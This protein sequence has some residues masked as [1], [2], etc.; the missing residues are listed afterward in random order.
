MNLKSDEGVDRGLSLETSFTRQT[1]LII[2][3]EGVSTLNTRTYFG[4]RRNFRNAGNSKVVAGEKLEHQ[5]S[6][7]MWYQILRDS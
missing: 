2:S 7:C 5:N 1:R 4:S 6:H 3:S